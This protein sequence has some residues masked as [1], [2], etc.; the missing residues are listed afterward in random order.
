MIISFSFVLL[1]LASVHSYDRWSARKMIQRRLR[2]S[3]APRAA[4]AAG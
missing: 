3:C 2:A 1:G 4:T